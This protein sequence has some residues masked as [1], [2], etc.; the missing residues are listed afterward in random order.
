M[1]C[2][3]VQRNQDIHQ[4]ADVDRQGIEGE[5]ADKEGDEV[6][7]EAVCDRQGL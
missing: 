6:F 5:A 3:G 7:A 1:I 4:T 2:Q